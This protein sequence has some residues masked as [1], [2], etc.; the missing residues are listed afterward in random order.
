MG[1]SQGGALTIACAALE[2]R[3]KKLA[4]VFP[5]LSD[6]RRVWEM[7]LAKDAYAELRPFSVISIRSISAKTRS[8]RSSAIS[9]FSI[10]AN[11]IQGEVHD[12]RRLDGYDLSAV[13][14]V[15]GV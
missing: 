11:R 14:A 8:S 9:T 6:Y 7:D 2:P 13:H 4:P 15:C 3:V 12:G 1:G 10:L 5:F